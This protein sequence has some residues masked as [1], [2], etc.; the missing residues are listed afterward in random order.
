MKKLKLDAIN[1]GNLEIL[2]R[3]QL[4]GLVGG[5]GSGSG[6]GSTN[7]CYQC[8]NGAGCSQC[9]NFRAGTTPICGQ[10]ATLKYCPICI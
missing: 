8:C 1:F 10:G 5:S 4:R 7:N 6:S 3:E 2:T 9:V